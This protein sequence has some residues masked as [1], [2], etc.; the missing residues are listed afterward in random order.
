MILTLLTV[1]LVNYVLI[2]CHHIPIQHKD[3]CDFVVLKRNACIN[4]NINN[5]HAIWKNSCYISTANVTKSILPTQDT[6]DIDVEF[7]EIIIIGF[8]WPYESTI[9]WKNDIHDKYANYRYYLRSKLSQQSIWLM[10]KIVIEC[11][12]KTCGCCII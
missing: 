6:S 10:P 2:Y 4:S 5:H 8:S 3:S 1:W 7:I 12:V 9:A 11:C